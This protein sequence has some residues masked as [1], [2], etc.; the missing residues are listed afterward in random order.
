MDLRSHPDPA[1]AFTIGQG[2]GE[3]CAGCDRPIA[4]D[5]VKLTIY[6]PTNH[7]FAF[8]EACERIYQRE[9]AI[10]RRSHPQRP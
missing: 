5:E 9:L 4:F 1:I 2:T 3:P 7:P 10:V 8:H 6:G